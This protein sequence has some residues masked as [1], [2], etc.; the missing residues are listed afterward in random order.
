MA[1][2]IRDGVQLLLATVVLVALV[3]GGSTTVGT[4]RPP[5]LGPAAMAVERARQVD[6]LVRVTSLGCGG[7]AFGSGVI[8]PGGRVLTN[9]H[10]VAGADYVEVR[11]ADGRRIGARIERVGR[12]LDLAVLWAGDA[13]G[14]GVEPRGH[15]QPRQEVSLLGH[16]SGGP[17]V[18]SAG[19]VTARARLD[20]AGAPGDTAAWVDTRVAPGNSGG[21]AFNA[22]D[23]DLVGVV[24]A[25]EQHTGLAG[26]IDGAAAARFLAGDLPADERAPCPPGDG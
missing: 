24:F 7:I 22:R 9:R 3:G 6:L 19:L 15:L 14:P 25:L 4:G 23:G 12:D 17:A 16:P 11:R 20:G 1:A 21:P 18:R 8:V 13:L 5:V 26:V 10:V 2:R